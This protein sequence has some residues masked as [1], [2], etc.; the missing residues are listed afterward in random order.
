MRQQPAR[1]SQGTEDEGST[2]RQVEDGSFDGDGDIGRAASVALGE[3]HGEPKDGSCQCDGRN[4]RDEGCYRTP[5]ERG[6]HGVRSHSQSAGRLVPLRRHERAKRGTV[7]CCGEVC[8]AIERAPFSLHVSDELSRSIIGR[9]LPLDQ[10]APLGSNLT[11]A[12]EVERVRLVDQ[13]LLRLRTS[14]SFVKTSRHTSDRSPEASDHMSPRAAEPNT[15]ISMRLSPNRATRTDTYLWTQPRSIGRKC[16]GGEV[17]RHDPTPR[18]RNRQCYVSEA[19]ASSVDRM[20]VKYF[21]CG[22]WTISALVDCSGTSWNS[23]DSSTPMRAGSSS[24]NS[25]T[26]PSRSGHAG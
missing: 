6:S 19:S 17:A 2:K 8:G 10:C 26:W 18:R 16:P 13:V 1:G 12:L 23:S 22:W 5:C 20:I 15:R 3:G 7:A 21:A 14:G 4:Y 11:S 25:C 24:S 9:C